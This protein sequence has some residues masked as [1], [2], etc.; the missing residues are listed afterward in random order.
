VGSAGKPAR[1][2]QVPAVLTPVGTVGEVPEILRAD[3]ARLGESRRARSMRAL[4]FLAAL[5]LVAALVVQY[6]WFMPEDLVRRYPLAR[7]WVDSF[8]A[9]TGCELPLARDAARIRLLGRDVRIHPRYEGALLVT[10]SFTNTA[11][12]VQ[13]Y[14]DLEFTLYN[15]NGQTIAA[16]RFRP[17]DYLG[18]EVDVSAGMPPEHPVQIVLDL[19]APE[20]AAV[21]FEFR[22]I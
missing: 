3:L 8:C 20:E 21:S 18:G 22:F 17:D 7:P 6:A 12:F 4:R 10:A 9:G 2:P 14:P 11:P 13:P 16:R 5:V 19:L 1:R 15:V